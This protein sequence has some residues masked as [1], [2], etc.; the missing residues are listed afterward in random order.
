[1]TAPVIIYGILSFLWHTP[2]GGIFPRDIPLTDHFY[3]LRLYG[4]FS[5][6]APDGSPILLPTVSGRDCPR[7]YKYIRP[8]YIPA[9]F[10]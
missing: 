9:E 8:V 5:Y 10:L 1:M 7:E 4:C 3:G 6:P 2:T